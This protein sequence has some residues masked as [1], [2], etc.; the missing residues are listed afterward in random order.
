MLTYP[1]SVDPACVLDP[2]VHLA[3][4]SPC[5][6]LTVDDYLDALRRRKARI[7]ALTD[8]GEVA[9]LPCV[10]ER[11]A[12][13]LF[14]PGVEVCSTRG[15]I[16][17]YSEDLALLARFDSVM[18]FA[19]LAPLLRDCAGFRVWAHPMSG[20]HAIGRPF[21]PDWPA[22]VMPVVDAV[23]VNG[24]LTHEQNA[25][26]VALASQWG[27]SVIAGSDAHDVSMLFRAYTV[28]PSPPVSVADALARMRA[29]AVTV[30][31]PV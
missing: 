16:L 11:L 22:Q 25:G 31:G 8:H 5:S 18:D 23:E 9:H 10:R 24:R 28:F 7:A 14:L 6:S 17:I 20:A 29:G 15:D 1:P 21:E 2:H 3:P 13:L 27:R 19:A 30:W 12:E 26:A 4:W